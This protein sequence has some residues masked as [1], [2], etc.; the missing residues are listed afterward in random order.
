MTKHAEKVAQFWTTQKQ[1]TII[2]PQLDHYFRLLSVT[3]GYFRRKK[4]SP[5]TL[6]FTGFFRLFAFSH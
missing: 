2:G 5:K 1:R 6:D 4:K 3:F